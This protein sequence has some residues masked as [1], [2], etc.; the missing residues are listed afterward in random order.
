MAQGSVALFLSQPHGLSSCMLASDQSALQKGHVAPWLRHPMG[1]ASWPAPEPALSHASTGGCG[2]ALPAAV[3]EGVAVPMPPIT[4]LRRVPSALSAPRS[5]SPLMVAPSSSAA[6]RQVAGVHRGSWP[7]SATAT[8]LLGGQQSVGN[9]ATGL[10]GLMV[11]GSWSG[12]PQCIPKLQPPDS[13]CIRQ[14]AEPLPGATR[15]G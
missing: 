14:G 11:L 5:P 8:S 2:T 7:H 1:T 4:E 3:G 6:A 10:L 12:P 15:L 13:G 9:G